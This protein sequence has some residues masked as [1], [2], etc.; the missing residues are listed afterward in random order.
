MYPYKKQII[1]YLEHWDKFFEKWEKDPKATF[2]EDVIWKN[3]E[4]TGEKKLEYDVFPQPY[5]GN[6]ENHSVITLNLNP[7]RSKLGKKN[8]TLENGE[9]G[10][11]YDVFKEKHYHKFL[12]KYKKKYSEYAKGFPT[13]D[14]DFWQ[15][16]KNWIDRIFENLGK[17]KP[18]LKDIK[19]FAIEICPWGSKSFQ[20]L[21][22]KKDDPLIK[23]MDH[24]VFDVIEKAIDNS[25]LKMVLSVGKAYYDIF[26]KS[27]FERI[28]EISSI[29]VAKEAFKISDDKYKTHLDLN[30]L[31]LSPSKIKKYKE[32][33]SNIPYNWPIKFIQRSFSIWEKDGIRYFNTYASGSNSTPGV[34]FYEIQNKL[35]KKYINK[36]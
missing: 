20:K 15:D 8:L 28:D 29:P 33:I 35:I 2:E 22:I 11:E 31:D 12:K 27:E 6:Y 24:H 23:Y 10:N 17:E 9:K 26:K 32:E 7:S 21:K 30:H 25:K 4:G 34:H 5:L 18:S 1:K 16:Q 13:Y 36:Q 3:R 14:I 19:P